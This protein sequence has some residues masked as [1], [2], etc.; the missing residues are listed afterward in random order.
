LTLSSITGTNATAPLSE[1]VSE[2]PGASEIGEKAK[3]VFPVTGETLTLCPAPVSVSELKTP[4]LLT[5][6]VTELTVSAVLEVFEIVNVPAATLAPGT[7][8]L[9]TE[10]LLTLAP[11]PGVGVAT[12]VGVGDVTGVAVA[13][14]PVLN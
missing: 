4:G 14:G 1:K 6:T 5:I 8:V 9:E 13:V 10:V 11:I 2:A 12:G 7:A 3:E